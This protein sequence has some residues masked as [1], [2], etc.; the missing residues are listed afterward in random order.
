MKTPQEY[1]AVLTLIDGDRTRVEV[2]VWANFI[3]A[4]QLGGWW[5]ILPL[6]LA[7]GAFMHGERRKNQY[8]IIT[9]A[10][11]QQAQH[12]KDFPEQP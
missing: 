9:L 8:G 3:I 5:S 4:C 10:I 1:A 11:M 2:A 12:E 6:I 7:F